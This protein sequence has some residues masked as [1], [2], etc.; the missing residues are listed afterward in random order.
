MNKPADAGPHGRPRQ[1]VGC[2]QATG[3]KLAP[4]AP[5][6]DSCCAVN[7]QIGASRRRG[8]RRG[9]SQIAAHNF[10]AQCVKEVRTALRADQS[11]HVVALRPQS[12]NQMTAQEAR[13]PGD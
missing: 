12:F 13:G 5:V 2:V 6:T 3:L 1:R 9:L 8:A 7:T 11:P 10:H 4:S